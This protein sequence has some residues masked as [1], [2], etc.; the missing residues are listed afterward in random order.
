MYTYY[1]CL[2]DFNLS[3]LSVCV[4]V[5]DLNVHIAA[6]YKHSDIVD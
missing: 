4:R 3:V 5:N 1:K 6:A 2:L